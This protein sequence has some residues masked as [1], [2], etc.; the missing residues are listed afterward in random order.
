MAQHRSV[1]LQRDRLLPRFAAVRQERP[2]NFL[3]NGSQVGRAD[4]FDPIPC[5]ALGMANMNQVADELTK[6]SGCDVELTGK[7]TFHA[8]L[9][10]WAQRALKRM[11]REPQSRQGLAEIV[12][13]HGDEVEARATD[14]KYA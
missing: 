10:T 11:Q 5:L 14:A 3:G 12:K 9:G 7:L 8:G 6:A 2:A 4:R 1:R 13:S